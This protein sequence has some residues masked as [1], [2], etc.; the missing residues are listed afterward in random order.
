MNNPNGL[1][2]PEP[3]Q[4]FDI[5]MNDGAIIRVRRHGNPS[6]PRIFISHG[7]G[8][9]TNGY[10]QFWKL[11]LNDYDLIIYDQ[12]SHGENPTHDLQAH[13]VEIFVKDLRTLLEEIPRHFGD[14][15]NHGIFH[16]LS[17]IVAVSHAKDFPWP[18]K[19]LVLVDPPFSPPLDHHLS[20]YFLDAEK[21][22]SSRALSRQD[23]FQST[24]ELAV[25]FERSKATGYW[26][27]KSYQDMAN[28]T[29]RVHKDG[30]R[31]S[32]PPSHE[33]KIFQDNSSLNL[34]PHLPALPSSVLYI[35]AD[36]K[37]EAARG[38]AYINL[39][40]HEKYGLNYC[41]MNDT[42]HMLQL[43]KPEEFTKIVRTFFLSNLK[44]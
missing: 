24:N 10:W 44:Q 36:P 41:P 4:R 3:A 23:S 8:F 11:L 39:H 18:W 13:K 29:L 32:C 15:L 33:A 35:C 14:K 6:G 16:S 38:P 40:L 34:T 12:R 31:L 21:E 43:E 20:S 9:A 26:S 37:Q 19:S 5:E 22:L 28:A 1:S 17:A 25:K 42:G 7:N 27:D 30:Y 2:V